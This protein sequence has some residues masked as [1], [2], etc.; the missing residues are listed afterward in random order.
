MVIRAVRGYSRVAARLEAG[1]AL[2]PVLLLMFL[3]TAIAL[4][5]AAVVRIEVIVAERYRQ[6]AEA[7]HAAD[8]AIDVAVSELRNIAEWTPVLNGARRSVH[9]QGGFGGLRTVPGGGSISLCCAADSVSGRLAAETA[10]S[11]SPARRL[12]AWQPFLWA[13]FDS[14]VPRNPPSRLFVVVFVGEDE[15][16]VGLDGNRDANETVL[17]RA[18]AVDP[19]GIRRVIEAL[20]ARRPVEVVAP[21]A[22][23]PGPLLRPVIGVLRWQEAR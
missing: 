3:F 2:L 19:G 9:S 11:A 18:E 15:E 20:V 16:E 10:L 12:V 21:E 6:S 5:A 8:G 14:L 1:S 13:T 22:P 17:V 23:V 4:G 7:M